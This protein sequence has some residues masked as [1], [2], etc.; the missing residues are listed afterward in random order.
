[1][2]PVSRAMPA[3]RTVAPELRR[4][5]PSPTGST[6]LTR[7]FDWRAS[8][9]SAASSSLG[10]DREVVGQFGEPL[11]FADPGDQPAGD[12]LAF[13]AVFGEAGL[14]RGEFGWE[15]GVFG[16]VG[17]AGR[18]VGAAD[19]GER[20]AHRGDRGRVGRVAFADRHRVEL[21]ERGFQLFVAGLRRGEEPRQ[22]PVGVPVEGLLELA[23]AQQGVPLQ[24]RD[25]FGDPGLQHD[26]AERDLLLRLREPRRSRFE[27]FKGADQAAGAAGRP[28]E[29]AGER[30]GALLGPVRAGGEQPGPVGGFGDP[31]ADLADALRGPGQA[32]ADA[33][34]VGQRA[35]VAGPEQGFPLLA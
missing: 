3:A 28:A 16:R 27:L 11:Q 20:L 15:A 8:L 29:A 24:V 5:R 9:R 13:V 14:E 17:L 1:M 19:R 2:P 18:R 22:G 10:P 30:H 26:A 4:A 21:P 32:A 33:G 6:P 25:Q 31:S 35:V 34:D 23:R 12:F 7:R